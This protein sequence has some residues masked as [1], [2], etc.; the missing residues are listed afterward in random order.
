MARYRPKTPRSVR[1][2]LQGP[3][4]WPGGTW[5]SSAIMCATLVGVRATISPDNLH[6]IT[7]GAQSLHVGAR[8][9]RCSTHHGPARRAGDARL[10][11]AALSI[12]H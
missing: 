10:L 4:R 9:Q 11:M 3:R 12:I 5:P 7:C 2:S 8:A 1:R 6:Q